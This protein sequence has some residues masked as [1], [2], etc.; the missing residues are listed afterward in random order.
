MRQGDASA[1]HAQS[2]G[3]ELLLEIGSEELPSQFVTPALGEL[4]A[5]ATRCFGARLRMGA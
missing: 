4:A 1:Q 2:P 3:S 5:Q